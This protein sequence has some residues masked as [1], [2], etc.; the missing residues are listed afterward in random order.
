MKVVQINSVCGV[1][2]TGRI[3]VGISRVLEEANIENYILYTYGKS[4]YKYAKKVGNNVYIKLQALLS[5]ITGRYGFVSFFQT[6]KII[7]QLKKINPDIVH[8]HNIHGHDCNLELLFKYLKEKEIKVVFTL[9]DCWLF[10]GYCTY[11]S[12]LNCNKWISGC[13]NCPKFKGVS[14]FFDKSKKLQEKKEKAFRGLNATIITPSKWLAELAKQS[15]LKDFP[16]KVIN[17]GID[18]Q[19]FSPAESNLPEELNCRDKFIVLG[20]SN[21][22]G[23]GKGLDVFIKLAEDLDESYKIILVGTTEATD[24][25]LP[26]NIISVHKTNSVKQLAEYYSIADVFVNPTKEENFPTVNIENLA[27]GTPIITY[28]TGGSPEIIDE[29]TGKV[30]NYNDYGQLKAEIIKIKENNPFSSDACV[31]RAKQFDMYS[32][33][34]EYVELYRSL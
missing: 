9:H 16:I 13:S 22:W 18:L 23:N 15:F 24:K 32:K 34:E 19:S 5:R 3:A 12:A 6:K 33:F 1:G 7:K 2:S 14:F 21:A 4:D 11:F 10:T 26:E 25:I 28:R 27:C 20:V 8:I 29:N 17:N 30:V 31:S